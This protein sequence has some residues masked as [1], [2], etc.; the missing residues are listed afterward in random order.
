MSSTP[1]WHLGHLNSL[2]GIAVLGVL[3]VHSWYWGGH[4][5]NLGSLGG[6]AGSGQRG[7]QLFFIVSAFTLFLSYENRRDEA[8]PTV[9]FFIRRFFRLA[10][11]FYTAIILTFFLARETSGPPS[12]IALAALFMNGLVPS[13]IT[14]GTIGGW[15]VADEAIFYACLPLAFRY[16]KNLKHAITL[17]AV[18]GP[19]LYLTGRHF[20]KLY[21]DLNEYLRFLGFP[22]EVPVFMMGIVGYFVW[23]SYIKDRYADDS[24]KYLSACLLVLVFLL[25]FGISFNND[26]LYQTSA[27]GLLLL[28]ALS[29]YPWKFL[30]NKATIFLGKISY[31]IYLLHF[32]VMSYVQKFIDEA[33]PGHHLLSDPRVQFLAS[34]FIS[35]ALTIPLS[36]ITWTWIER[37]GI[38]LGRR[39][40]AHLEHRKV[41]EKDVELVPPAM[42]LS[43]DGNSP[44]SQF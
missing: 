37:P 34:L 42:A 23:R 41:R 13:A 20:G 30:V 44:D 11:M 7:V 32:F 28:L 40:I 26:T 39:L 9:N 18:S 24:H 8:H 5:L 29:L 1:R 36:T 22:I 12:H 10:P 6:I 27:L 25:F 14:H 21:P 19:A 31:S 33:A 35:L 4:P 43:G 15:S 2:R 17:L 16:I 38:A 3:I